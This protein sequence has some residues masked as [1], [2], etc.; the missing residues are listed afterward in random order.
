MKATLSVSMIVRDE[1]AHLAGALENL[2]EFADEVVVLDTGSADNTKRLAEAAGSVK[3][4][5]GNG[6][7]RCRRQANCGQGNLGAGESAI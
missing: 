1:S 4:G 3:A 5:R 2:R 7:R 6:R